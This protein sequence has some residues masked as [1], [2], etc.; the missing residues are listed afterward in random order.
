MRAHAPSWWGRGPPPPRRRGPSGTCPGPS[1]RPACA[2]P[3]PCPPGSRPRGTGCGTAARAGWGDGGGGGRQFAGRARGGGG[4][5]P[6]GGR[7]G[8]AA[9]RLF[10][11][12]LPLALPALAVLHHFER[13]LAL[14]RGRHRGRGG[15][16]LG[17]PR[18]A[19]LGNR[20][21]GERGRRRSSAPPWRGPPPGCTPPG[22]AAP[23]A[24]RAGGS[25]DG[26][27][28]CGGGRFQGCGQD[29]QTGGISARP[30]QRGWCR[31][32]R[33]GARA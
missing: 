31:G 1:P 33:A 13:A 18:R 8:G 21:G 20:Q 22:T 23:S 27:C 15:S 4:A 6:R 28:V 3:G 26:V 32:G 2:P 14:L 5:G 12:L 11:V 29:A 10:P 24:S 19:R 16:A 7:G 9:A 17:A 25:C 30:G